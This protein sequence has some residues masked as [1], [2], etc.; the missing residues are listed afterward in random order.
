MIVGRPPK[1]TQD[2]I[3]DAAMKLAAEHGTANIT[4]QAIAAE[5]GAPS[6]SLYHRYPSRDHL[7]ADLWL[8][9]VADFQ[10]ALFVRLDQCDDPLE[11]ACAAA[12]YFVRW[13]R[14]NPIVARVLL[15]FSVTDLKHGDWPTDI[16]ARAER[17]NNEL[18][19]RMAA[20]ERQLGATTSEQRRRIRMCI[21]DLPYGVVRAR[22]G[23][24]RPLRPLD[25]KL[26]DEAVRRVLEVHRR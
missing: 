2:T 10:A 25:E 8:R 1:F 24:T 23:D 5:L 22:L 12:S 6:G 9:A 14:E 26:V 7:L 3:V 18:I 20:L 21:F 4:M 19:A 17:A 13:C 11:S 16:K 15:L